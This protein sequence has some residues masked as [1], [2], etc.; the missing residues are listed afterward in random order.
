MDHHSERLLS[1]LKQQCHELQ[2]QLQLREAQLGRQAEQLSALQA[3]AAVA[4]DDKAQLEG[5]VLQLTARNEQLVMR[6]SKVSEQELQEIQQE[7]SERLAASE[8][9]VGAGDCCYCFCFCVG[10]LL[11]AWCPWGCRPRGVGTPPPPRYIG[12]GWCSCTAC[13]LV[14]VDVVQAAPAVRTQELCITATFGLIAVQ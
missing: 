5:V 8:R 4:A 3:A 10:C 7:A 9:K 12:T 14:L 11:C 1:L 2:Q 6:A 13:C